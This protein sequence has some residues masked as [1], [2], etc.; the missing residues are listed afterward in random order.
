MRHCDEFA[1]TVTGDLHLFEF[2]FHGL[3]RRLYVDSDCSGW[4]SKS[5][6][7]SESHILLKLPGQVFLSQRKYSGGF[8]DVALS[9]HKSANH[10][11]TKS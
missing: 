9:L 2:F 3:A 5:W 8:V 4:T 6:R 7:H 1:R 11:K 10:L